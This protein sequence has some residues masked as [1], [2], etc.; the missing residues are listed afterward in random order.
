MQI[1]LS[2]FMYYALFIFFLQS[3]LDYILVIIYLN[4]DYFEIIQINWS[5]S[6][7]LREKLEQNLI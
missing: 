6:L 3:D 4:K 2:Q 1:F 5:Q 7:N